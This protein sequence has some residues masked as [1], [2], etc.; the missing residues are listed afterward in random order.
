MKLLSEE[1]KELN[2]LKTAK[3]MIP[4]TYNGYDYNVILEYCNGNGYNYSVLIDETGFN[5]G[6][7]YIQGT[8]KALRTGKRWLKQ[9]K[10]FV[11][12]EREEYRQ[13]IIDLAVKELVGEE[14]LKLANQS[15]K[16]LYL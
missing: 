3:A 6:K 2:D 14:N 1:I 9:G 12:N 4:I 7:V 16:Y 15:L 11:W 10:N 13:N 8:K 5:V